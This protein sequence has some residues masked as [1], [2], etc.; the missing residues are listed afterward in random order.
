MLKDLTIRPKNKI[1]IR[2]HAPIPVE[3]AWSQPLSANQVRE[4]LSK[5]SDVIFRDFTL[6][7]KE[8]VPCSLVVVDGLVDKHLLDQFVLKALMV[9]S[10]GRPELVQMTI[11]TALETIQKSLAPANEIKKISELGEA[12]DAI[13]SG[14]A[15]LFFAQTQEALVIGARGWVNRGVTEPE[16]E[17]V[18]RG[19]REG[20]SETL[21]INTSLLRRK[22][23]HP[24]LRLVSLK[25][26][27]LTRTDVVVTYLENI[28]SSDVISEVLK[29]LGRIK[30]DGV[31]ETAYLEQMI[32]DNPYSPFPQVAYTERPDALAAEL[33]EG[34]VGILVDGTPIALTVPAVFVQFL[35]VS[36]DYYERAMIMI[37][38]RFIRYF[39]LF[40]ALVAPSVY[41][42]ATTFHQE[43]L[44]TSMAL[45]IAAAR[46]GVPFP[47]LL[48]A[49]L[50][51][52]ILEIL[53]EA[54]LRLPKP[55]G[56][57]IGIVGALVIG[58]AAVKASLVSPIMVII[59]GITAVSSYAI[60]AYDMAITVRLIR[61]PLTILS[62]TLGFFGVSI[63]LYGLLIHV[64]SL[65]SFGVPYFSPIVPLRIRAFLQDVFVVV[66]LW[67]MKRRPNLIDTDK[68]KSGRKK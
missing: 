31:L 59:V 6:R 61:I 57:T 5:S 12:L 67:A 55:I 43:I 46:E 51:I 35:Q 15:V 37:L 19:P 4:V 58:D 28:A 20:F 27:D 38:V 2:K 47:A 64:L 25:I 68:P 7:G 13:L 36:E 53:Q 56:Q 18:V 50:M 23:K 63:A 44:P 16:T 17:S 34:K 22:I 33:L 62:G 49:M 54:G 29:R 41:I 42:A 14:D 40:L 9:D 21:R 52:I 32:E 45:S 65:R 24:S 60:P 30:I 10:A 8:V 3:Q 66:P 26:G 11:T 1:S 48:E 39:G